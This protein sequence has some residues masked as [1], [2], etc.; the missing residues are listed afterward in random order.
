MST[1][2]RRALSLVVWLGVLAFVVN[3]VVI[4]SLPH[5]AWGSHAELFS[6]S[7]VQTALP[8][9]WAFFTRDPQEPRLTSYVKPDGG[10]WELEDT[11]GNGSVRWWFGLDRQ[12]RLAGLEMGVIQQAAGQDAWQECASRDPVECL[13]E[14][15]ENASDAPAVND[16][17]RATLCGRVGIV[18]TPLPPWAWNTDEGKPQMPSEVLMAEVECPQI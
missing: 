18:S 9:G 2:R 12:A 15:E 1:E 16:S 14:H 7:T 13:E 10:E 5:S 17:E 8:Q 6:R 11:G 3:S 4:A